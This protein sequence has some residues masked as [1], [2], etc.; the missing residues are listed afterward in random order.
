MVT[1]RLEKATK[2]II[3]K[4]IIVKELQEQNKK[5]SIVL[6]IIAIVCVMAV[7][8]MSLIVYFFGLRNSEIGTVGYVIFFACVFICIF[9]FLY[10]IFLLITGSK[11]QNANNFVVITDEVV[12]KEEKTIRRGDT[13]LIKKVI[14][15]YKCGEIEVNSTCYQITGEKDIFY[16]VVRDRDSKSVLKCYPAKLYEYVE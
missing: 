9:P 7:S 3:N 8:C 2:N 11:G 13:Y 1:I 4:E 12:Y 6:F 15:F 10:L 5:N 16:M 14:H